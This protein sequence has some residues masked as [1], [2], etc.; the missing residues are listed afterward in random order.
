M[1]RRRS[2]GGFTLEKEGSLEDLH[3]AIQD[4]MPWWGGHLW[5][6]TTTGRAR[7]V[8]A[9]YMGEGAMMGGMFEPPPPR[10]ANVALAEIFERPGQKIL[11]TY[12]FGDDWGHLVTYEGLVAPPGHGAR[13]LLEGKGDGPPEDCGGPPGYERIQT[14]LKTG[15]DPWGEDE[16]EMTE[17]LE[18]SGWDPLDLEALRERF[19]ESS[20]EDDL[21]VERSWRGGPGDLEEELPPE[22]LEAFEQGKPRQVTELL[23]QKLRARGAPLMYRRE[24]LA[25]WASYLEDHGAGRRAAATHAACVDY[26]LGQARLPYDLAP[27]QGELAD[28][29]GISNAT[30]SNSWSDYD[31][32]IVGGE[33][34][35][36]EMM[37]RA[38]GVVMELEPMLM[39]L[40]LQDDSMRAGLLSGG[41]VHL[42]DELELV[43]DT[44][45][46]RAFEEHLPPPEL[47]HEDLRAMLEAARLCAQQLGISEA[48]EGALLQLERR[49]ELIT[50][51]ISASEAGET[52]TIV[53]RKGWYGPEV[54]WLRLAAHPNPTR[55]WLAQAREDTIWSAEFR[56]T[57]LISHDSQARVHPLE[58]DDVLV[59]TRA[60]EALTRASLLLEQFEP[61]LEF[62]EAFWPPVVASAGGEPVRV[63]VHTP[64]YPEDLDVP[65]D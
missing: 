8:L 46:L 56:P 58:P 44:L 5:E 32:H 52:P 16:A 14:L 51:H 59:V 1:S 57:A 48:R 19:E 62:E 53:L 17:W 36:Q 6:F 33:R 24:A 15:E 22:A 26:A 7:T 2:G 60:W 50:G 12:D 23:E 61:D 10:A 34:D 20:E 18:R 11:Y 4:A 30:I 35:P 65:K 3:W 27:T 45:Q 25:I 39:Q 9:G 31:A 13:Y 38:L 47:E 64:F 37:R 41:P 29:Y 49:G 54:R 40:L 21:G 55:D 28:V 63:T 42:G 43:A